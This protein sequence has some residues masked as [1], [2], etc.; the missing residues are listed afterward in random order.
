MS[1]SDSLFAVAA[2]VMSGFFLAAFV[3]LSADFASAANEP[4][5]PCTCP[6]SERKSARPKFAAIEP[7]LDESDEIATLENVHLALTKVSDGASYVFHRSN[8][9]LSGLVQ[10]TASFRN[11]KGDI[12]RH[13]VLLLTTGDKT[14]K[15]EGVACRGE[16][17]VW[18]LEG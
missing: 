6:E 8:G 9:R 12:C 1:R 5:A 7:E 18:R 13:L 14:N 17:G 10:P 2:T 4:S 15:T 3:F 11:S 16:H